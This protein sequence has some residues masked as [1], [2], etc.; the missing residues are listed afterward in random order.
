MTVKGEIKGLKAGL[1]GFHVHEFGDTTDGC[2]SAGPH[3]NPAGKT[4]GGP[5]DAERHAGDLGNVTAGPDGVAKFELKDTQIS[6]N[7]PTTIVG[8]TMVVRIPNSC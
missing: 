1:H 6:L 7:G 8:R 4:H 3:F 2:T 5:G